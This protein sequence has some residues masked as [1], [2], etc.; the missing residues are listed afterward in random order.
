M[1]E[2]TLSVSEE[3]VQALKLTPENLDREILLAAAV[4]LYELG[5]LSSGAAANLARIPRVVFLAKLAEFGVDTFRLTESE[6]AEDL[7]NQNNITI[8]N[9]A[10]T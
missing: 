8:R 6:L 7:A 3:T 2:I 4:K 10:I 5:R 9:F 1:Y